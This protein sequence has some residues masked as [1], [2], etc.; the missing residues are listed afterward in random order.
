MQIKRIS[1][2]VFYAEGE[3]V[4]LAAPDLDF[5]KSQTRSNPRRRARLCTHTGVGDLLHEMIIINVRDT[6]V[7]PHKNTNK[8]KSFQIIEG[9]MDVVVFDDSG[10]ARSVTRLG[11]YGSGFPYYFRLHKTCYHTLRTISDLVVFQETTI[12][13][14]QPGDTVFAPWAPEDEK[15][16]ECARFL[17]RIDR[18]VDRMMSAKPAPSAGSVTS[19]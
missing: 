17:E 10:E 8:P 6:Y 15:R 19:R 12:G 14:F 7:R 11:S 3:I 13:P 5:L 1:D 2:E 4:T 18:A 16:D 9:M